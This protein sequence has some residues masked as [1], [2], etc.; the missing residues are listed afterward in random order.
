MKQINKTILSLTLVAL[1]MISVAWTPWG[2][3]YESARDERSVSDQAVDKKISL[4]IKAALA[5]HDSK[6]ALKVHVYCFLRQVYLVGALDNAAYRAFAVM[7]AESEKDAKG[8]TPYFTDESDTT[9]DDTKLAV[10]VR[11]ALIAEKELSSTQVETEV[12][13]GEVVML[14]MVRTKADAMLAKKIAGEVEGVR[15][16]TSFLIPTN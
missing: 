10:K 8:V 7:T 14:G 3:I 11:T 13:N 2:A 12:M 16:V 9:V 4:S 1:A 6:L 5:D 15:Q